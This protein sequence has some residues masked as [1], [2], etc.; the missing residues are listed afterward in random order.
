MRRATTLNTSPAAAIGA[1]PTNRVQINACQLSL[2]DQL[3]LLLPSFTQTVPLQRL[4]SA[5][6]LTA[7]L[8]ASPR[9]IAATL[10]GAPCV[11][12][13]S[14]SWSRHVMSTAFDSAVSV[15][16]IDVDGD[17]DVDV[18]SAS[19]HDDTIAW[20]E[21]GAGWMRHVISTAAADGAASVI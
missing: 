7:T 12:E 5:V 1:T 14:V 21:N 8:A 3:V 19:W 20:Y 4:G 6:A 15:F 18:L 9:S 11:A 17:G 16:V 13:D 2:R 10:S